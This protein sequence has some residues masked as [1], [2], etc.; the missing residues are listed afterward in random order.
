MT[1]PGIGAALQGRYLEI[2]GSVYLYNEHRGYTALDRV[3]DAVRRCCPDDPGF[4]AAVERHLADER[5]HYHM[6]RRWFERRGVM[7]L[8]MDHRAGHIDRFIRQAFGCEIDELETGDVVAD[9]AAFARLCRVIM[10]TEQRGLRQVEVLLAH[11]WV[12]ADPVLR[13]IFTIIHRDEPGHVRPYAGWLERQ[14]EA[15]PR[16]RERWTDFWIHRHLLLAHLP[17]LFLDPA[18]PRLTRW[19]HETDLPR[20][21][22]A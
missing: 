13:R 4:I 15:A 11:R 9:R 10:L 18:L 7:P 17:A 2:L 1:R 21:A 14:G 8:A 19:P 3:L 12:R 20:E 16:W 6:F 5:K 22:A